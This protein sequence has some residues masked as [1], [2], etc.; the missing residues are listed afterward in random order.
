MALLELTDEEKKMIRSGRSLTESRPAQTGLSPRELDLAGM[1]DRSRQ[2]RESERQRTNEWRRANR[3]ARIDRLEGMLATEAGRYSPVTIRQARENLDFLKGGGITGLRQHELDVLKQ[4]GENA[5]GAEREKAFG[6]VHQGE[7]AAGINAREKRIETDARFGRML[8]DGTYIPGSD[9]RTAEA[10]GL[11]RA[12]IA[13]L[14]NG[15]RERIA[16]S[17]NQARREITDANNQTRRDVTDANNQTRRD[18]AGGHDKAIVTAA[19]IR[20][21]DIKERQAQ[22]DAMREQ[23]DFENWIN[24]VNDFR[25]TTLTEQEKTALRQM[26]PEEQK[27]YWMKKTGR[28][29]SGTQVTPAKRSWR[30]RYQPAQ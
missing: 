6:M 3:E 18:V 12:E 8:E 29:P 4:Q 21:G 17:N 14:N 7:I 26:T 13:M 9:V 11:S 25:N 20:T 23:K 30:D 28:T 10:T 16:D 1:N 27:A 22:K 15:S 2:L 24:T 19:G 5:I